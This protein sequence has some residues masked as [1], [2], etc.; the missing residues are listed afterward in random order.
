MCSM[1]K[2]VVNVIL[3]SIIV[4]LTIYYYCVLFFKKININ[5]PGRII[6]IVFFLILNFIIMKKFSFFAVL[7]AMVMCLCSCGPKEITSQFAKTNYATVTLE[8]SGKYGVKDVVSNQEII[9]QVYSSIGYYYSG[10]FLAQDASGVRLI[11]TTGKEVIP[12]QDK[13][14]AKENYFE[15]SKGKSTGFYF[16]KTQTAVS[17]DYDTLEVDKAGNVLF[18]KNG[19]AGIMNT[20]GT[21]IIPGEYSYLVFDGE[22]YNAAKNKNDKR[23]IVGKNG[24]ANWSLADAQVFD[25]NGKAV[26]K[27]TAAQA[28]KVFEK[29]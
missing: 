18:L 25:K 17:G 23:P 1:I 20:K 16:I 2:D 19:L 22:N 12:L 11:D 21:V 6:I 13:I 9:P 28:K 7:T 14:A 8:G 24:K 29:K 3:L 26:K 15:F 5:W 10:Y 4:I 27:L